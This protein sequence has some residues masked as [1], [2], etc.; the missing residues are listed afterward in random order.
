VPTLTVTRETLDALGV[1]AADLQ[2]PTLTGHAKRGLEAILAS[3]GFDVTRDI[4]VIVLPSGGVV[5]SQ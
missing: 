3:R 5:L 2:E 4:E 1:S